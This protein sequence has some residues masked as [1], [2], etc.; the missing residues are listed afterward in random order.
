MDITTW[1][2]ELIAGWP[3]GL[4]IF[5]VIVFLVVAVFAIF[6]WSL[7]EGSLPFWNNEPK[8]MPTIRRKKHKKE[9]K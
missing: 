2:G 3:V 7:A 8:E 6:Y 5:A 1:L 9:D 4:V